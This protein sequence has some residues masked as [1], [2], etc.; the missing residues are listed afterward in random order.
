MS[1]EE[2]ISSLRLKL[3]SALK[4]DSLDYGL[5]I[6]LSTELAQ[7]DPDHVRFTV[8]A[9][10]IARLGR[11]LVGRQETAVTEL[12]KNAYDA[13]ATEV[14]LTF[15]DADHPGGNLIIEDNG[16]G[17]TRA[18]VIDG[19]MRISSAEKIHAPKSSEFKRLRA[20]R[21][22]IG[23]F[24]AQRLGTRL[25]VFTQTD[26]ALN[27]LLIDFNWVRFESDKDLF[28]IANNIKEL[29]RNREKKSGTRITI[30]DLLDSWSDAQ[31]Q[32]VYRYIQD[33]IPPFPIS[34]IK[35]ENK[36]DPGFKVKFLRQSGRETHIIADE[37]TM[38]LDH[39]LATI[40]G[41]VTKSGK[42]M[43]RFKSKVLG[44][45]GA[46]S[47]SASNDESSARENFKHL[48]NIRFRAYY[49]IYSAPFLSGHL[50][51]QIQEL[52]REKGGIRVYR[53]GF[54]VVP[55][56]DAYNDWL[57]LDYSSSVRAI[58]PPHANHNFFGYVEIHDR[59]GKLFEETASREGLI[60]NDAYR[61]LLEFVAGSLKAAVLRI[62]A[63]RGKKATSTQ[64]NWKKP[65]SDIV[66]DLGHVADSITAAAEELEKKGNSEEQARAQ[67]L[68]QL[69]A[70][71][72]TTAGEAASE[73]EELI[74]E[75][76]MLRVLASLG[77]SIGE[78]TH[79]IAH[80][81]PAMA[82]DLEMFSRANLEKS[83]AKRVLGR[84]R[85]NASTMQSYVSYFDRVVSENVSRDLHPLDLRTVVRSFKKAAEPIL[86]RA[87]IPLNIEADEYDLW[88]KP[89]HASEWSSIL[90]NFLSNSRKAI[91][92][93]RSHGKILIRVGRDSKMVFLEFSDNGDGVDPKFKDKIFNAFFT[94]ST[95]ARTAADQ[96]SDMTGTGLGLKLVQD[97]AIAA[98]GEVSLTSPP[99]G[100][101]T[102]FRVEIPAASA[103]EMKNYEKS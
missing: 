21:K 13:D 46:G 100:Y 34:K 102:C 38:L 16:S 15:K 47:L 11:E 81:L 68:L 50:R 62:A 94:T 54:R 42:A 28:S 37:R 5:V 69:A 39:A 9:G 56:G 84:L 17:M 19:F 95:P 40:D 60:E 67:Q 87:K 1:L 23:R 49:Y 41:A 3:I 103:E 83:R 52:A 64:K 85:Q 76:G 71:V 58:L 74:E 101:V 43:W 72:R 90:F 8:D 44:E 82:I 10:H 27:G 98:G 78:F 75:I 96:V 7:L 18:E 36:R 45:R 57:R 65:K 53:N 80:Y 31:I 22:G 59:E 35:S 25:S 2:K 6:K 86:E 99:S 14:T 97:I 29:E 55:Y 20:G 51:K 61:E 93:A 91:R 24:A 66:G 88:T 30:Q 32:R 4:P 70:H 73:R 89:M 77:L 33:L 79:E 26:S 63:L 48:K 92:R 12:I